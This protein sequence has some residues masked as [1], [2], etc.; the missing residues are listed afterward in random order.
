MVRVDFFKE[1]GKWH[2]TEAV[3]FDGLDWKEH[4][5]ETIYTALNRH[6]GDRLN[7]MTAVILHPYHQCEHPV[8]LKHGEW[9]KH[10]EKP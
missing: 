4:F 9:L 2:S 6:L 8:M 7:E 5:W 3:S 10:K 1:S